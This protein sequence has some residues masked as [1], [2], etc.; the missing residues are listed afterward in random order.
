[1]NAETYNHLVGQGQSFRYVYEKNCGHEYEWSWRTEFLRSKMLVMT[2]DRPGQLYMVE[3]QCK[4]MAL[5]WE[6][7]ADVFGGYTF[8]GRK[9]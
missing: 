4:P 2:E 9:G 7:K 8:L 3:E 5:L 1:M 6:V